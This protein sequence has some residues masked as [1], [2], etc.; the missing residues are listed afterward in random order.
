M[1]RLDLKIDLLDAPTF[2]ELL[3]INLQNHPR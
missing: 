2:F 1:Q 3:R